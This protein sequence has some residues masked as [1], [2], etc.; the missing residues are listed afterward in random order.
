MLNVIVR[1]PVYERF[2]QV[3]RGA[4]LLFV[5]GETQRDGAVSNLLATYLT[6][7]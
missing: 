5:A 4:Q 7:F 3:I 6:I 1:P 2:R